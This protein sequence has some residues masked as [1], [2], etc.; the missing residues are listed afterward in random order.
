MSVS[1]PHFGICVEDVQRAA[2]FYV[3]ALGF[4]VAIPE[5]R[6]KGLETLLGLPGAEA[7]TIFIQHPAGGRIELYAV[8]PHGAVGGA[9]PAPAN[10]RGMSHLCLLVDDLEARMSLV[11]NWGGMVLEDTLSENAYGRLVF[12]ADPDGVRLELVEVA[13][14]S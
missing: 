6:A 11:R 14:K 13:P 5:A 8:E 3:N 2:A 4:E 12:C 1:F 10:R 7:R 9:E